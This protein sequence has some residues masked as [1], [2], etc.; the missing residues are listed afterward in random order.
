MKTESW[1]EPV[2]DPSG[3][4]QKS[5]GRSVFD[6]RTAAA[7]LL[8]GR[9]LEYLR[10]QDESGLPSFGKLAG[11]QE[12]LEFRFV[13][14]IGAQLA[15]HPDAASSY[16][17]IASSAPSLDLRSAAA[18]L[19]AI[20][21]SDQS[22]LGKAVETLLTFKHEA[23]GVEAVLLNVH[24]GVRHAEMGDM[25][26]A[27]EA[28][29][30]ALDLGKILGRGRQWVDTLVRVAELNEFSFRVSSGNLPQ[31]NRIPARD[32]SRI[33]SHVDDLLSGG[34]RQFFDQRYEATFTNPYEQSVRWT[35]EDPVGSRINGALLR[36]ECLGEWMSLRDVRRLAGRYQV[37]SAA[38][39][40]ER[41]PESGFHLLRRAND[42][43]G[44]RTAIELYRR[45]GPLSAL[46]NVGE[47]IARVRWSRPEL[48]SNLALLAG[49]ADFL[50][51]A[52]ATSAVS[53]ILESVPDS[54]P[55]DAFS[56]L[57]PLLKV[58]TTSS[59]E[60]V[61]VQLRDLVGQQL[62][63]VTADAVSRV[64]GSIRWRDVSDVLRNSWL[65]YCSNA[66][67]VEGSV[68]MASSALIGLSD[69]SLEAAQSLAVEWFS[70]A[71]SLFSAGVLAQLNVAPPVQLASVLSDL[72]QSALVSIREDAA[73]GRYAMGQFNVAAISVWLLVHRPDDV[74]LWRELL[75]FL[76]D[77]RVTVE[78]KA[79]ALDALAGSISAVPT[80]AAT[81]LESIVRVAEAASIPLFG[82]EEQ[83]LGA[84]LRL[85][86]GLRC[87]SSE[88]A[89]GRL[90][91]LAG[92][93]P[94]G[95][96]EAARSITRSF[97]VIPND[98]LLAIALSLTQ[99]P[100]VDVRAFGAQV[101]PSLRANA[102]PQLAWLVDQRM[103]TLLQDPGALVTA[104][105]CAGLAHAKPEGLTFS[106]EL[107]TALR[108]LRESHPSATVR[109]RAGEALS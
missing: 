49:T 45:R 37:T 16:R 40:V 98:V 79:G 48:Q 81:E 93:D 66:L 97:E 24:L 15:G 36:A 2:L 3:L 65:E 91:S 54:A 50:S 102:S 71:P 51:E 56:S 90:L 5:R 83:F 33:L 88:E 68:Q 41:Q 100:D 4:L 35:A 108:E 63:S 42:I 87:L 34:L 106:S 107:E 43:Q 60:L 32:R 96:V 12:S 86:I 61:A 19:A 72:L 7:L 94:I 31:S 82:N 38:G 59:Q 74:S 27:L 21:F 20:A 58:A 11:E 17:D 76:K 53:R 46:R 30:I 62:H 18:V 99:D 55:W 44:L 70:R 8:D 78:D 77:P 1:L 57:P 22:E 103:L 52:T 85:G 47:Q 26:S 29:E 25:E 92:G 84:M 75:Q 89:V 23:T 101:L 39:T 105:A 14:T 10:A 69:A 73:T 104:G 13:A 9:A 28:T 67:M 80:D 6:L 109:A 95:R 64:L